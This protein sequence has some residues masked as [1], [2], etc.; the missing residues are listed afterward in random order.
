MSD[1]S[2]GAL[3]AFELQ[4]TGFALQSKPLQLQPDPQTAASI[5]RAHVRCSAENIFQQKNVL[6]CWK[7]ERQKDDTVR[8]SITG[9]GN[10]HYVPF[11]CCVAQTK[12]VMNYSRLSPMAA[13]L[14]PLTCVWLDAFFCRAPEQYDWLKM[15]A[16]CMWPLSRTPPSF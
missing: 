7:S 5:T 13:H 10:W 9:I 15:T 16:R 4:L 2:V 1:Q 3:K 6:F 14:Q 12:G 11:V 8:R